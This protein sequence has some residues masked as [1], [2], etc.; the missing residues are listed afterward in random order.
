[1]FKKK[2]GKEEKRERGCKYCTTAGAAVSNY[3][4]AEEPE[5]EE[6]MNF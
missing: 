4:V 6:Q 3:R 1:M 2:K 5:V